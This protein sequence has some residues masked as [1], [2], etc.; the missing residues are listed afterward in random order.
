MNTILVLGGTGKTGR[1][2]IQRLETRG[3]PYRLASR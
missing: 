2:I 3:V 1:R